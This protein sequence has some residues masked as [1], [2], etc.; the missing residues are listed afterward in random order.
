MLSVTMGTDAITFTGQVICPWVLATHSA[1]L[2]DSRRRRTHGRRTM[3]SEKSPLLAYWPSQYGEVLKVQRLLE[4][5]IDIDR[6][7]QAWLEFENLI[8][9]WHVERGATSSITDMAMCDSYLKII[10]KGP[11]VVP[12]ILAQLR[13]EGDEPDQWFWALQFL[14]GVDPVAEEDRGDFLK[15]SRAWLAWGD[16]EGYGW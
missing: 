11:D 15:M 16:A 2:P 13:S 3:A 4:A 6:K 5:S 10:A 9:Q 14:A 7:V 12:L 8:A 1:P